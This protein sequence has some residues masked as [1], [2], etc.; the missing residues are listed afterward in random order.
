[1]YDNLESN[2]PHTMM[3]FTTDPSLTNNQLFP[4]HESILEY[5]QH[6]ADPVYHLIKFSTR[7]IEVHLQNNPT[8]TTTRKRWHLK[9]TH[10]PTSHILTASYDAIIVASGHYSVPYIPPIQG[11]AAWNRSY[12]DLIKHSKHYRSPFPYTLQRTLLI[13]ASASGLDIATQISPVCS[14]PLLLSHH[15]APPSS[16]VTNN[17]H[18]LPPI[19]SFL[20]PSSGYNRAVRL[21]NGEIIDSIDKVLFCTGY[22]YSYPFLSSLSPPL[23]TTGKRIH[24]LYAHIFWHPEPT[25]AFVAVPY[26]IIPFPTVE[27]QAALIAR[28]WSGRLS[29]PPQPDMQRWEQERLAKRG[30]EERKFHEMANLEDFDYLNAL[31]D[32]ASKAKGE[33]ILPRKWDERDYWA[34]TRFPA[35]KKAFAEMGEGRR[36]VRSL[37]ALG[38]DYEKW[39]QKQK[40]EQQMKKDEE[41]EK[42]V[43]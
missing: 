29:L 38:F 3:A 19:T 10:L 31:V 23:I 15:S 22:H 20:P 36:E 13:G 28:V 33:G 9:A 7:V 26:K 6:Y 18:P 16:T 42:A 21:S 1:M 12:P 2:I 11:L 32:W 34:R 41:K 37:E 25:L 40:Q 24:G 39:K 5:L 8:T 43:L 30:G 14:S 4:R 35:I 27:G 17:I